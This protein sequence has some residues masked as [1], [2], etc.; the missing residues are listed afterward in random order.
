MELLQERLPF[1]PE[2]KRNPA[3]TLYRLWAQVIDFYGHEARLGDRVEIGHSTTFDEDG[4]IELRNGRWYRNHMMKLYP[5][6]SFELGSPISQAYDWWERHTFLSNNWAMRERAILVR[7]LEDADESRRYRYR[8]SF[9]AVNERDFTERKPYLR[10]YAL[11]AK[12]RYR[13]VQRRHWWVVEVHPQHPHSIATTMLNNSYREAEDR[14]DRFQR[15]AQG[16]KPKPRHRLSIHTPNGHKTDQEAVAEM[17]ALMQV[18][19][20]E[21]QEGSR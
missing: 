14:Y 8:K 16:V 2:P 18:Y 11:R 13:L 17:A 15:R 12:V 19:V 3:L 21:A 6:G 4:A 1:S 20:P 7:S 9:E 5:D 10:P